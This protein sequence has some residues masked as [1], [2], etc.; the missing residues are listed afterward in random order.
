MW[1]SLAYDNWKWIDMVDGLAHQD[2][3]ATS[4]GLPS[5]RVDRPSRRSIPQCILRK[6]NGLPS[7]T[8][9]WHR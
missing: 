5:V 6:Y 7:H 9:A 4:T 8:V 2:T 1:P 3:S